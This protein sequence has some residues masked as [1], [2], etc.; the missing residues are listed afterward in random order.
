MALFYICSN[1]L[2]RTVLISALYS[3]PDGVYV[4]CVCLCVYGV[5]GVFGVCGVYVCS[6]CGLYVVCMVCL[7]FM[8]CVYGV[9][10]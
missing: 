8:V 10:V 7:V 2:Q 1:I 3:K 4:V 9:Y 6:M 5:Y